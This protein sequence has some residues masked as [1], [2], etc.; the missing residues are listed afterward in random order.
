MQSASI[1]GMFTGGMPNGFKEDDVMMMMVQMFS[2]NANQMARM[3][4]FP[5][6]ADFI[7]GNMELP[8]TVA[9]NF[10]MDFSTLRWDR[11]KMDKTLNPAAMGQSLMKQYLWAQDM[12]GAFHDADDNT[13]DADGIIT[14]DY[15]GSPNFDLTNNV[16]YGG[17]NLD[18]FMGQMLTAQAISKTMF[19]INNMAY[20]GSTLGAV[21]PA[22][23]NPANG[24][25]YFSHKIAV[26]ETSMGAMLPPMANSNLR[27]TD[28]SSYLFDQLSYLWATTGFKN[29]MDP[30]INDAKHYAYHSVFD[31][32]PFPAAMSQTGVP[33]PFD[34]M[35][36]TS[37]VIFLNTIAMHFNAFAG[38]FVD[39]SSLKNG[40][41]KQD[42]TISAENAGY[43]LIILTG[44]AKEFAGTPMQAMA[45]NAL[46]AQADFIISKLKD[47]DGGFYNS[48]RIGSGAK[49]DDG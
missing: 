46:H 44:F 3:G 48:Y 39:I 10:Q 22:T 16:F 49:K 26:T 27:V 45:E 40:L 5:E 25:K 11:N 14:P 30:S 34:L 13:I 18:G 7:A 28:A 24:I 36:G 43:V 32:S 4:A 47:N 6:F 2:A 42:K 38:T 15:P 33:G 8:Q 20:N 37:K 17:N 31:G 19:L 29:M 35:M 21:D 12:L 1:D 41:V 23:Y 9:P